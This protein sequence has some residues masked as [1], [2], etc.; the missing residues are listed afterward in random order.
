MRSARARRRCASVLTAASANARIADREATG[1]ITDEG[2]LARAWVTRFGRTVGTQVLGALGERLGGA[3]G[4]G[5]HVTVGGMALGGAGRE[6]EAEE[7]ER[8]DPFALPEW[9]TRA[10][11]AEARTPTMEE[12]ILGSA[13]TLRAGAEDGE[14]PAYT[15]WGR[16]ARETFGAEVDAAGRERLALDGEVTTGLLGVDAEWE[17][18]LAGVVLSRSRGAGTYRG[19]G[20]TGDGGAGASR[21]TTGDGD[22]DR[23]S[24]NGGSGD[25]GSGGSGAGTAESALTGVYP[26]AR[27]ALGPRVS[28]WAVAGAGSGELTLN[29][30]GSEVLETGTSLTLGALGVEGQ[31]LD[32]T[33]AGGVSLNVRTDVLWMRT[34]SEAMTDPRARRLAQADGDVT[35]LRLLLR[36]ER[37]FSFEGGATFTPSGEM[38][39]R[40][41][42]GDAETGTGV[43]LGLGLRYGAGAL[44]AQG[45]F[46][47]LVAHEADGYEE[48]GASA[49]V[50]YGAGESGRGLTLELAPEWGRTGS[51]AEQLWSARAAGD[52]VT[53]DTFEAPGRL[54]ADLGYG[55][56]LGS[57]LGD[58]LWG[59]LGGRDSVLTPYTG[60]ALGDGGS[61]QWRFGVRW[62]LGAHATAGLEATRDAGA[63]GGEPA[64]ALA[65][66]AAVRF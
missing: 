23:G 45:R 18:L 21:S 66:R 27:L 3:G 65:L 39:L 36:T 56:G 9:A 31:V 61:R 58:G 10:R 63:G 7:S 26:Y 6:P 52:L 16:V 49:S 51:A 5:S 2:P 22:G 4:T 41:D 11:E 38:G 59:G 17:G 13:F 14:G 50:R 64:D 30:P 47:A 25:G 42:G 19:G 12:L 60:L 46:R 20:G 15:A 34:R 48:W 32:G 8:T 53:G 1:R 40:H 62:Q 29:P 35:R 55:F 28:A 37:A 54:R 33:G 44:T 43:E 57:G 24:G